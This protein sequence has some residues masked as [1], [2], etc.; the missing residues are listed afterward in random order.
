MAFGSD[1]LKAAASEREVQLIT[2][3][4]S[5]G[6]P[7]PVTLWISTDGEHVYIRSGEGMK[8]DWPQNFLHRGEATLRIAGK[9]IKVRPRRVT[10][11]D[12]ARATS[13]LVRKKYGSYV[14]PSK[15]GEPLTKGEQAVFELLP[16]S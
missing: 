6:K 15:P 13:H 16:G 12:E 8:R 3:G 4:R 9:S 5:S 14:K 10:D 11:P 1:V 7:R 2:D